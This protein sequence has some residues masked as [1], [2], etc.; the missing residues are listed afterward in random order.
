MHAKIIPS[1]RT[2]EMVSIFT[3]YTYTEQHKHCPCSDRSSVTVNDK[4]SIETMR[5]ILSQYKICAQKQYVN[6][7]SHNW[8]ALHEYVK[9]V[10]DSEKQ[11][12]PLTVPYRNRRGSRY[13]A[14]DPYMYMYMLLQ[15]GHPFLLQNGTG[16]PEFREILIC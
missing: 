5:L 2:G 13:L 15:S 16:V 11:Y 9:F 12:V 8:R 14:R 4:P 6:F 3:G 10:H 7:R 1:I